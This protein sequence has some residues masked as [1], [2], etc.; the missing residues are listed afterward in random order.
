MTPPAGR[1]AAK[2]I[3]PRAVR[4][5]A[6]APACKKYFSVFVSHGAGLG[7]MPP[8]DDALQSHFSARSSGLGSTCHGRTC[9]FRS[10]NPG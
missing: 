6:R 1:P 10:L 7:R 2:P 5:A 9:M 4:S 3:G 8:R